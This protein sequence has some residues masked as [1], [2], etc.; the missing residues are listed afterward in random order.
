MGPAFSEKRRIGG[1][2]A[3][4]RQNQRPLIRPGPIPEASPFVRRMAQDYE[5]IESRAN[6]KASRNAKL[7]LVRD[8]AP[9][10]RSR[11]LQNYVQGN[12]ERIL[13]KRHPAQAPELSLVED[14]G[15]VS[16]ST[17]WAT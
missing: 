1:S 16:R 9:I 4:N 13:L 12:G 17:Q 2:V 11:L 14:A 8:R 7:I 6:G 3:L 5:Q 15:A 10:H